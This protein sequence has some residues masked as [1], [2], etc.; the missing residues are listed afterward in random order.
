MAGPGDIAIDFSDGHSRGVSVEVVD[1]LG[2]APTHGVQA[3]VDYQA[4][5]AEALAAQASE[6]AVRIAVKTELCAERFGVQTP[7]FGEGAKAAALAKFGQ[8]L[9]FTL[10]SYLQM[11]SGNALMQDERFLIVLD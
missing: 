5:R 4:R 1:S 11:M 3:G 7:A 2:A 6:E 9:D 8:A 10:Q